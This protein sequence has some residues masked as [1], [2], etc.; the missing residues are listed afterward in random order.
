MRTGMKYFIDLL[1]IDYQN[2]EAAFNFISGQNTNSPNSV[3]AESW[4]TGSSSGVLNQTGVFFQFRG[5]G[6]F[7]GS[8]YMNLSKPFTFDNN[9]AILFSYEKTNARDEIIMSSISGTN[10]NNYSGFCLGVNN[11]NK[12]YFKYWNPVEG[13]FTFTFGKNL[14]DKNLI[15]LNKNNDDL[16]IGKFNNNLFDF[17]LENFKFKNNAFRE[18]NKLIIGG[19]PNSI[20]WANSDTNNFSGYIDNFYI[21][22]NTSFLYK[23]YYASG[24]VYSPTGA[25]GL[26]GENCFFTGYLSGSGFSFTGVTGYLNQPFLT[27]GTGVTGT[28]NRNITGS[29][30]SGVTGYS[31]ISLGFFNDGCGNTQEIF[32]QTPLSGLITITYTGAINLTGL[33]ITTGYNQIPLSGP[34]TGVEYVYITGQ[35]CT[36][37]FQI[38]GNVL[39]NQD[40]NFLK[41]LSYS[42]IS[43]LSEIKSGNHI[44]EIYN[45]PYQTNKLNYNT[46]LQY[47]L[48]NNNIYNNQFFDP[49]FDNIPSGILLYADKKLILNSGFNTINTGYNNYIIPIVDYYSTGNIVYTNKNYNESNQ[50]FYDY[51]TGSSKI[52]K[53]TGISAGT[54][55]AGENFDKSFI[56]INGTK[57]ISGTGFLM[58]NIINITVPSGDNFIF[59]KKI[60]NFFYKSGNISTL[61]LNIKNL[62]NGCSQIF[63]TGI[64]QKLNQNYIENSIYDLLSG[65]FFESK[66]N[67][68]I[69]DNTQD[70][71]V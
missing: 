14:A 13:P 51:F 39:F 27:T 19:M 46:N 42:Q 33:I 54:A 48:T 1:S 18:S 21:F 28:I 44:L 16:T 7:N 6:H 32:G 67:F 30:Y 70:F 47:S 10:F 36:P 12:L 15:I 20:S 43:L 62:N 57:L 22:K 11:A 29:S 69:Y 31:N 17:E 66:N 34:I 8:T 52:I 3:Y 9:S 25:E 55:L 4:A 71:F 37:F 35:S 49:N 56:F 61:D 64:K 5:T 41:S 26:T 23:N 60:P 40:V 68:I 65:N 38:T 45:E 53:I 2:I 58:P 24:L 63:F 50:L 59:I